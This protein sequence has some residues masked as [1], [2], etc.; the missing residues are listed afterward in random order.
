M[1]LHSP[2]GQG[3][4]IKLSLA[5][6]HI[7]ADKSTQA[8]ICLIPCTQS[9]L[10]YTL[11]GSCLYFMSCNYEIKIFAGLTSEDPE[12]CYAKQYARLSQSCTEVPAL[13]GM[14]LTIFTNKG[15]R[16]HIDL[17]KGRVSLTGIMRLTRWLPKFTS[18]E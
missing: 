11:E 15:F 7:S 9:A 4:M 3:A 18:A 12:I 2:V 5:S 10:E 1:I 17:A 6:L 8:Y 16:R 13:V 14:R